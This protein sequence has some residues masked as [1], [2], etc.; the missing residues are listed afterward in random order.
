MDRVWKSGAS[1][2]PPVH[3]ENASSGYPTAGNP[4]TGTPATKPGPWM[5]H[6]LVEEMLAC[7]AAASITPDKSSITQLR[8]AIQKYGGLGGPAT[9]LLDLSGATGGQIKFPAAQNAS[10]DANT[11]DDYEEG[12][13]TP[14][15]GGAGGESGQAYA[16]RVG[17]Y[18]K[19]GRMVFAY[20]R[21]ELSTKGTITGAVVLKGLPFASE[22]I[23]NLY[24]TSAVTWRDLATNWINV[25]TILLENKTEAQIRGLQTA[26]ITNDNNLV[27]ADISNTTT[28]V[29]NLIYRAQG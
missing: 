22:N 18:V 11:L 28:F 23:G 27:T 6:M 17:R 21:A 12:T 26:G 9:A 29:V 1:G 3:T 5:W 10:N 24:V 8:D 13:W 14:T 15:I 19:I 7:L 25:V 16:S 4:G 2:S 20:G